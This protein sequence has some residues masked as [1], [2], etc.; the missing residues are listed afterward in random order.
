MSG[1]TESN[2]KN[3]QNTR[4]EFVHNIRSTICTSFL[5]GKLYVQVNP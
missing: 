5:V 4:H 2:G 1:A 3:A